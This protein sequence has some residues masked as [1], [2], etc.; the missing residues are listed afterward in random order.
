M[1]PA[2]LLGV[3]LLGLTTMP[4]PAEAPDAAKIAKL[5]EQLGSDSFAD[6]Q[7]A[8]DALDAIGEPA[9]EALRKA[10]SSTDA[11]VRK[12][13]KELVDKIEKRS[14]NSRALAAKMVHL[15]YKD[16]PLPDA[17]ADFAKKSGYLIVLHDP[18]GKLKDKKITLDTGK[19]TFWNAMEQFCLKA[20]LTDGNPNAMPMGGWRMIGGP[21]GAVRGVPLPPIPPGAAPGA[22]PG[23]IAPPPPPQQEAPAREGEDV[24]RQG[25]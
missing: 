21:G 7:K 10:T 12:R 25:A 13:A 24:E 3:G 17:V 18:D 6:R 2:V 16:T 20:G 4:A 22:A 23:K 11:E 5:V 14:Y 15:Q 1:L 19:V 9:L 8:N